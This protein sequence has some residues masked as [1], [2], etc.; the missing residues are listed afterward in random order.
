MRIAWV[1]PLAEASAIGRFS[2]EVAAR[3]S[4][5]ADVEVWTH[6]PGPRL[7]CAVP[8]VDWDDAGS[9]AAELATADVVVYNVGDYTP[10]HGRIL[11]LAARRPGIVILHDRVLHHLFV[12]RYLEAGG[13]PAY[14]A[15]LERIHG[16][17]AARVAERALAAGVY[18]WEN[19]RFVDRHPLF[20]DAVATAHGVVV[21]SAT[22]AAALA[23]IPARVRQ[24]YLPAYG[25]EQP[26][27]APYDGGPESGRLRIMTVGWV[28]PNKH[29]DAV[30]RALSADPVLR[31]RVRYEVLGPINEGREYGTRLRALIAELGLQDEVSLRGHVDDHTLREEL[32]RADVFVNLRAPAMEGAS[33]SLMEM[34]EHGRPIVVYDTGVYAELPDQ[35]AVKVPVGD[36][37]ALAR[38][39]RA[40]VDDRERRVA[41]G[42][43]ARA[44]A[45]RHTIEG[46]ARGFLDFVE[47]VRTTRVLH[48]VIGETVE[49]LARWVATT[50]PD[51]RVVRVGAADVGRAL[52]P[53]V[54]ALSGRAPR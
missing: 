11:D 37:A 53:L 25:V 13:P 49:A 42:R 31:R 28:N 6:T 5:A 54:S 17:R 7:G 38:A 9:A 20:A 39:L 41:L 22:H 35:A 27:P 32:R 50:P 4:Q 3:L 45:E 47:D 24:L 8:V 30:V 1:A 43:A 51:G 48:D 52:A 29:V 40:L 23:G 36:G 15:A 46:Y 16:S 18:A 21:H 2:C 34:L 10:Y 44:C 26:P 33:A 12:E 14:I 19:D